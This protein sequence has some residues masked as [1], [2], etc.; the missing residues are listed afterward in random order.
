MDN[1]KF[2][3]MELMKIKGK[4]KRAEKI[5]ATYKLLFSKNLKVAIFIKKKNTCLV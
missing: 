2:Y 1:L 5:V 3:E 4:R